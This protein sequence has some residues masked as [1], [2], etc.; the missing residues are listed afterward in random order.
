MHPK[1]K[2]FS[3][4]S[5][6]E[7]ERYSR[8]MCMPEIGESGQ[9][10]LKSSSVLCVGCGGLGSPLLMYL[11]AAG[12]GNI[13]IVD[14]DLVEKSNLQRQV[15]HGTDWLKRPKVESAKARILAIN[16][17]SN[18]ETFN[19]MLTKENALEI[20]RPFDLIC[21]CTDNFQS[22]FLIND[23]SVILKKPN[24]YGA[25]SKF[26]G[27]STIFNLHE[28]SPNLRDLIPEP[29]PQN[30]LPS[31]SDAGVI[32]ILPGLIGL[33]QATEVIKVITNIGQPLDGRLLVFDGL[34]MRFK[35]LKLEKD[36]DQAPIKELTNYKKTDSNERIGPSS[37]EQIT[38]KELKKLLNKEYSELMLIDV[39]TRLE[40][41]IE[42][43]EKSILI[44]LKNIE[45]GQDIQK[46]KRLSSN[47]KLYIHCK[48]GSR[49]TKAIEILQKHGINAINVIGGIDEWKKRFCVMNNG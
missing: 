18:V 46:I 16:P 44:P 13:G 14:S 8:H 39:R 19:K 37:I 31:C 17:H 1:D 22:K 3:T 2:K 32:G 21:D 10:K 12:I 28:N 20:I 34:K 30:L 48:S 4:L 11:A 45:N 35:E 33:I 26:E 47:K 24:I 36:I 5:S 23:A 38:V 49:S 6:D 43:I 15:I 40:A 27:H 42:S 41:K 25:V 9:T 7:L 29:P